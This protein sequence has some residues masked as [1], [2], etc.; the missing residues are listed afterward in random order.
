MYTLRYDEDHSGPLFTGRTAAQVTQFHDEALREISAQ[1][2]ADVHLVLNAKIK[3]PTPY[4]ETQII[5]E[6]AHNGYVVHDRGIVYGPW[7]EGVSGRNQTT[8]F[9]GYHAFRTAAHG[10][11]AKVPHIVGPLLRRFLRG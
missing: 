10:L 9:K 5:T 2:S 11:S 3:H 4:Y 7:L 1:A 6:R 8:R